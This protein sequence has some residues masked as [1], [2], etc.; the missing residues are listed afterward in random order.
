VILLDTHA[1]IWWTSDPGKLSKRAMGLIEK[2]AAE[3]VLLVSA[4]SCWELAVLVSNGRIGFSVDVTEWIRRSLGLPFV[5]LA[6]LN[7]EVAVGST[8]L[9]GY[10][11]SDPADRIIIAT[12]LLL[13]CALVTKDRR[14]R[15]YSQVN[16]VW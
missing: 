13:G 6:E 2:E 10:G 11:H 5:R 16:T 1:W 7:P 12:A 9:P 8:R 14:I 4:I 3:G 15:D